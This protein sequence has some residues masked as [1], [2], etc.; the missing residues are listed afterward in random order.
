MI[1]T[2]DGPDVLLYHL[3]L[4][5]LQISVLIGVLWGYLLDGVS[6]QGSFLGS[7]R[8]LPPR[9]CFQY[10]NVFLIVRLQK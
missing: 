4:V 5:L 9:N 2:E 3:A 10:L 7:S 8:Y 1:L 6:F